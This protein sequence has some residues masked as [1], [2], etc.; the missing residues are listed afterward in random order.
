MAAITGIA[1]KNKLESMM[2]SFIE[3]KNDYLKI[4]KSVSKINYR[5]KVLYNYWVITDQCALTD[6]ETNCIVKDIGVICNTVIVL[7]TNTKVDIVTPPAK[8]TELYTNF[9]TDCTPAAATQGNNNGSNIVSVYTLGGTGNIT[10]QWSV[11]PPADCTIGDKEWDYW[12]NEQGS[13]IVLTNDT[14]DTVTVNNIGYEMGYVLQCN[15]TDGNNRTNIVRRQ[16][17]DNST[18][19]SCGFAVLENG[20]Q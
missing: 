11:L 13:P 15:V 7:P 3:K 2:A 16:Y 4:G 12:V 20:C 19:N 6:A 14:T 17:V 18:L 10:Y 5:L 1:L 8:W 9:S